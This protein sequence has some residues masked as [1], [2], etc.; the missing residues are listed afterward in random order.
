[1]KKQK[2][3]VKKE[4]ADPNNVKRTTVVQFPEFTLYFSTTL[5]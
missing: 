4:K 2:I 1:M 5:E 3:P